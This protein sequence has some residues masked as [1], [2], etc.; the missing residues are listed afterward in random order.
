MSKRRMGR[1]SKWLATGRGGY[2]SND[3]SSGAEEEATMEDQYHLTDTDTDQSGIINEE[4]ENSAMYVESVIAKFDE[5]KR[6][7]VNS[8][9]FSGLL[10]LPKIN[11]VNRA[12]TVWLLTKMKWWSATIEA[13]DH[14]SLTMIPEHIEQIVGIP[15]TGYNVADSEFKDAFEKIEFIKKILGRHGDSNERIEAAQR[16]IESELPQNATKEQMDRF[17]AAFVIFVMDRFLAPTYDRKHGNSDFWGALVNA[18]EIIK[19]NW[20]A[21]ILDHIKDAARNLEWESVGNRKPK[22]I[23]CCALILQVFYLDNIDFGPLNLVHSKFPRVSAFTSETIGMMIQAD[24]CTNASSSSEQTFG[25]NKVRGRYKTVYSLPSQVQKP[26]QTP[27]HASFL[28]QPRGQRNNRPTA[29]TKMRAAMAYDAIPPLTGTNQSD[30]VAIYTPECGQVKNFS[31]YLNKKYPHLVKDADMD[32]LKVKHA[33]AIQHLN[34]LKDS[35]TADYVSLADNILGRKTKEQGP[36][37][38]SDAQRCNTER[39]PHQTG[40]SGSESGDDTSNR[41]KGQKRNA[42]TQSSATPPKYILKNPRRNIPENTTTIQKTSMH[43]E[44]QDHECIVLPGKNSFSDEMYKTPQATKSILRKKLFT[45]GDFARSPWDLGI[46]L[47][48]KDYTV[49]GSFFSWLTSADENDLKRSW[50]IH[51]IP[52]FIDING[53]EIKRQFTGK[54]GMSYEV[55]DIAIR[56]LNQH[57][58]LMYGS[59][60]RIRWRHYLESDFAMYALS[61][62]KPSDSYHIREQFIGSSVECDIPRCRMMF[63]PVRYK[64]CWWSYVMDFAFKKCYIIDPSGSQKTSLEVLTYHDGT[65]EK[66][67][68]ALNYTAGDLFIGWKP[69]CDLWGTEVVKLPWKPCQSYLTGLYT[70]YCAKNF[71]GTRFVSEPT[72]EA[73]N[74]FAQNL[75]YDMIQLKGNRATKPKDFVQIIED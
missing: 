69:Q 14:I 65:L 48:D 73:V 52:R 53:L 58:S 56:A 9:G 34:K 45:P 37:L 22:R 62:E 4:F 64:H 57:E 19:Y 7:L 23:A 39:Q 18:D 24:T 60:E 10:H 17:K 20:A 46:I 36:N 26:G 66:V 50:V 68:N 6:S 70:L 51:D 35:L 61:D 5:T 42:W 67:M 11:K 29:S 74:K 41:M 28:T 38:L 63:I 2:S 32:D 49:T 55:F 31:S 16:V 33:K 1:T 59:T 3:D 72:E 13:G 21:Y 8:I 43:I 40:L 44:E 75:L 27:I 71:N 30:V 47:P 15:S 12:F 54:E 25:R